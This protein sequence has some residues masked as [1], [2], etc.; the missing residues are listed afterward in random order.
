MSGGELQKVVRSADLFFQG[1]RLF[2]PTV[3]KGRGSTKQV[4]ATRCPRK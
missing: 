2:S 1:L 3:L 4:R